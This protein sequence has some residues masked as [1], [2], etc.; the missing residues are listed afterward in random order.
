MG[1]W[2]PPPNWP[3]PPH[4]GWQPPYEW[5]PDPAW[6]PPPPGWNFYPDRGN[7][8]VR[9]KVWSAVI[10]VGAL[11]IIGGG[12]GGAA[13]G[14]GDNSTRPVDNGDATM[15]PQPSPSFTPPPVAH[16]KG[17]FTRSC[18]YV[19]GNFTSDTP[20]GFRFIA[21][22]GLHNTGNV[23]IVDRVRASW[24]QVG[25]ANVTRAKTVRLKVHGRKTV[26]F[27]VEV[28]Q[29]QIDQIQADSGLNDCHVG[30][31]IIRTF[32]VPK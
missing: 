1:D 9:H 14:G 3:P 22:A 2:T 25:S 11:A 30:V 28:G 17:T 15:T 7:W 6:G 16:A 20:Q 12:I 23:G 10:A 26:N 32:G 18:T 27:T 13:A 5:R 31:T 21:R 29:D 8:L 4:P 19:L 24:V